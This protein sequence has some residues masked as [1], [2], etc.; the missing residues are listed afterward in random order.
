MA[1]CLFSTQQQLVHCSLGQ[2]LHWDFLKAIWFW[3][4]SWSYD[5]AMGLRK[6]LEVTKL[7]IPHL[8]WFLPGS[9]ICVSKG[10]IAVIHLRLLIL[11][12][13]KD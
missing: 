5:G 2:Q 1:D 3:N 7:T 12:F 4:F 6:R 8:Q 9:H 11:T 10:Q 13:E